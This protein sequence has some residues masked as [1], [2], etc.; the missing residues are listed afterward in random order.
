MRRVNASVRQVL[1]EALPDFSFNTS[2]ARE[3]GDKITL[4]IQITGTNTGVLDLGRV[5][6]PVPP[7]QP[8]GRTVKHPVEH[9]VLTVRNGKFSALD[10]PQVEGGG[11]PGLL[12]Q[13]GIALPAPAGSH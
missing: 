4:T 2:E 5:G 3:E 9:P 12:K 6:L 13:L 7:I 10:L 8:T 11:L 1:A